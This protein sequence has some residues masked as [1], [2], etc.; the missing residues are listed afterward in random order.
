M[1]FIWQ[2]IS[3]IIYLKTLFASSIE[4]KPKVASN[5]EMRIKADD[6]LVI[7]PDITILLELFEILILEN[8]LS[9][10]LEEKRIFTQAK[11][12]FY[13]HCEY[14]ENN[15]DLAQDE[16]KH[17]PI[18][19][20]T[21]FVLELIVRKMQERLFR[22]EEKNKAA[23]KTFFQNMQLLKYLLKIIKLKIDILLKQLIVSPILQEN[24][25]KTMIT[26]Y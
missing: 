1:H 25:Q 15:L 4:I 22:L 8:Q 16:C 9:L 21:M 14:L 26:I 24:R 11:S 6:F 13:E 5:Q 20:D 7:E 12:K 19:I 23:Q 18:F 17:M 10:S 2:T 3:A